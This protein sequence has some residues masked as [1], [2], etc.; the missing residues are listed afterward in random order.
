[1]Y[2]RHILRGV[3]NAGVWWSR[4]NVQGVTICIRHFRL[5]VQLG[6]ESRLNCQP[7][8]YCVAL[9]FSM[10]CFSILEE[11]NDKSFAMNFQ[12]IINFFSIQGIIIFKT[13][14]STEKNVG[15]ALCST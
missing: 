1:M 4:E 14:L 11:V 5:K 9:H 10:S 8:R 2:T 13:T 6:A 7:N 15:V 12:L 3:I